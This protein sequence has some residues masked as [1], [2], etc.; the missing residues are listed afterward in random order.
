[1]FKK[2]LCLIILILFAM[3]LCSCASK[4]N[5]KK[6]PNSFERER[7]QFKT[8]LLQKVK[9]P[10]EYNNN[11]IIDNASKITYQSGDLNLQA[12]IS[13]IPD[14]TKKY[15]A[16]VYAHGGF[17]FDKEDWDNI[18]PYLDAGF[19]VMTPTFRGENGNPGNFEFLY[20]EVDDLIN[21][22]KYLAN[23][24]NI[25][26]SKI[27]LAGHSCGGSLSMLVS[28]L[29]SPYSAIAT[30][31]ASPDQEF[32]FSHG[33]EKDASF[34][35]K[36]PKEIELRSPIDYIYCLHKPL[37]VYVGKDDTLYKDSSTKLVLKAVDYGVNVNMIYVNGDHTTS[38]KNSI[39]E[40]VGV[41][42]NK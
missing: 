41:F 19:I 40:S 22:G 9:A 26:S 25:D 7:S 35:L 16:V 27:F 15:P 5:L 31:G 14:D 17:A 1:M 10:Q 36:N 33:W 18:K 28:L 20:G 30:F 12:W 11:I 13:K 37:Y 42:K 39:E 24:K 2:F 6:D 34:D 4:Q 29:P 8:N 38:L 32:T 3:N 23:Q 21:A